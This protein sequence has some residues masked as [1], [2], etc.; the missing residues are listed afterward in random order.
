MARSDDVSGIIEAGGAP[1]E[2]DV[3]RFMPITEKNPLV[4]GT[5]VWMRTLDGHV[6]RR[7]LNVARF[8]L[9]LAQS[10]ITAKAQARE[11]QG[12]AKRTHSDQSR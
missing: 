11:R 2:P 3:T 8:G 12:K 6:M 9:F 4:A 10:G 5:S 1:F 7:P